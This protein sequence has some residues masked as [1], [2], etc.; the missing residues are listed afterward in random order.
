M[1]NSNQSKFYSNDLST[2]WWC[3]GSII[4]LIRSG[5]KALV[6]FKLSFLFC[7]SCFVLSASD[8]FINLF[9]LIVMTEQNVK[10]NIVYDSF[11]D[12]HWNMEGFFEVL[13]TY[14][15]GNPQLMAEDLVQAVKTMLILKDSVLDDELKESAVHLLYLRDGIIGIEIDTSRVSVSV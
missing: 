12:K 5:V 11:S 13:E 14:Y 4:K 8:P 7:A 3:N 10:S 15:E 9:K 2:L 6:V 1:Y